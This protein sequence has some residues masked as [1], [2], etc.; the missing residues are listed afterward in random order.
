[1]YK[2]GRKYNQ[3]NPRG[4]HIPVP[5]QATLCESS[6]DTV[7]YMQVPSLENHVM[8]MQCECIN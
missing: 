1:M 3:H 6:I 5:A 4:F 2:V 8:Y 7:M